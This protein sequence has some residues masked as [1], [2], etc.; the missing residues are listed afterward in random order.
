MVTV[1]V[2]T[3]V[4]VTAVVVV[5]EEVM[6]C[7]KSGDRGGEALE[8]IE[9]T[10][11]GLTVPRREGAGPCQRVNARHLEK[12]IAPPLA[13]SVLDCRK[14]ATYKFGWNHMVLMNLRCASVG[15]LCGCRGGRVGAPPQTKR[16]RHRRKLTVGPRS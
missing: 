1:V 7:C 13:H 15:C 2:E 10:Q 8:L 5:T 9:P 4:Y 14:Q 11:G 3:A 16:R 6:T 12:G